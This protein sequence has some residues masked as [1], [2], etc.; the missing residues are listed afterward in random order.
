MKTYRAWAEVDLRAVEAN[1]ACIREQVGPEVGVLA[2]VKADAYGHGAAPVAKTALAS[3][4]SLVGV[5]DSTEALELRHAGVRE[6]ILILGALIEEELGWVV[7]FEIT[8][9]IH[10]VE[11]VS[12]L[13][14]EAAR[15]GKRLRVHLKV[16]TGL[17]RLGA[18]PTRAVEIARRVKAASHLELEGVCTHFAS[19]WSADPK[20]TERQLALF[21]ATLAEIEG[22]G[23]RPRYRHAAN[24]AGLFKIPGSRYNLVRPGGAL[25]GIDTSNLRAEGVTLAPALA[26]KSQV[27]FLKGVPAGSPIGYNGTY[28]TPR[29]T[30]I[31]TIPVGYNDGYPYSLGNRGQV[32]IR[33]RVAPVVGTI[34]M[35][36]IMVDVGQVPEV[37]A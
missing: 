11:M 37:R 7:S 34:T 6:P 16:D 3:G 32:L 26:F 25:Y 2:V 24:G 17:G 21:A 1:L 14:H 18:S 12:V 9:T 19:V 35:D 31:A 27:A 15:Q 5:G 20:V 30:K 23:L 29:R 8:P 13:E 22:L 4:A 36:Y 33:G 10:A 28:V